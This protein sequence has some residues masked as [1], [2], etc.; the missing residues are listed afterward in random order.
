MIPKFL[1]FHPAATTARRVLARLAL[2]AGLLPAL[3]G[4]APQADVRKPEEVFRYTAVAEGDAI[5]VTWDIAPGYY[6]YKERMSFESRTPGVELGPAVMPEGKLH[7]DEYFGEMHIYRRQAEIRLPLA[8][9]APEARTLQLAV[10]S[11]GCSDQGLCYPPQVWMTNVDLPPATGV[12]PEGGRLGALLESETRPA[13]AGP[14]APLP[15]REAFPFQVTL[16]DPFTVQ[17]RWEIRPGYYLYRHS[18]KLSTDSRE[19]QLGPPDLPP[20]TAKFDEEFGD[21]QVF[22]DQVVLTAPLTR[23]G[24]GAV[25][26]PLV[27]EFQGCKDGSLC[28]PPVRVTENLLLPAISADQAA[29]GPPPPSEQDRLFGVIRDG[30]ILAVMALF[31]GLGLLL[32]FTPCCLPMYPILSGIIVGQADSAGTTAQGTARGFLLSLAF[33]LGMAATYTV[34]GAVFA[35]AGAQVQAVMQQPAVIIGVALLFVALALSMFGLFDLQIPASWQTRLNALSGRQKSGSLAGAA[36]MGMISAAV[37]T[38][39]VTPPLV[40]ALTVIARTGDV[41]RGALALFALGLG[42]GIPLLAIGA[43]AGRLIPKAGAWMVSVKMLFGLIMLGMAVWMLDRLWPGTVTLA[44]WGV[45]LVVGGVM[46]GA[47]SGLETSAS[48]GR[49]LGKGLAIVAVLYGAA[50][51]F[52]A[53]SGNEDPLRPLAWSRIAERGQAGPEAEG[54]G[55]TRIKTT[56]DLDRELA[57]A[58]AAGRPLMLDFYADW[59]ASCKEME[60]YTFPDPAVRKALADA[61]LLQ[62]DVTAVDAD[63]QALMARFGI[64]GPPTILFFAPDGT[65]QPARRVVGFKPAADFASHV[66]DA[67]SSRTR[68]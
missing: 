62:A 27:I 28:Y 54:I 17:V 51:F 55:F 46:L 1:R 50:L 44:L 35:A 26:L 2:L 34:L 53:L 59:C 64:I 24:P 19:A 15:V 48:T 30:H 36:I 56:V 40:A 63:D 25:T 41:A 20:G 6:L 32:S 39:C 33:V 42:M 5:R 3:A 43:S 31:A 49:R 9:R 65:E 10:R 66:R 23:S 57:R 18:L 37:I 58:K 68:T 22:Y 7:R 14:D 8:R 52:G 61:V 60:K 4:A 21:T 16:A 11:Q 29:A 45:L 13:N 38:T 12:G 67:L 47:F